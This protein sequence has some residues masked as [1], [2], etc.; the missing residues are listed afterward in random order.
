MQLL[1]ADKQ[2]FKKSVEAVMN[3]IQVQHGRTTKEMV[4]IVSK[5]S[6]E[7]GIKP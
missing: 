2:T 7:A 5:A 4:E 6:A 1:N 3:E